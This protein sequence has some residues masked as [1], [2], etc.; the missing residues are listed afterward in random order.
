[1]G[2]LKSRKDASKEFEAYVD[3]VENPPE[4]DDYREEEAAAE[5][6]TVLPTAANVREIEAQLAARRA[7]LQT[8]EVPVVDAAPRQSAVPQGRKRLGEVLVERAA[9]RD[10]DVIIP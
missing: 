1:M 8:G 9:Q 2:L 3:A 7:A 10:I 4:V 6:G 5:V